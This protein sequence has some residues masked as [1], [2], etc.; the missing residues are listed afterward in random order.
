MSKECL[1]ET[2]G[3]YKSF[4]PTRAL[5]DV[6]IQ[7][8]RGEVRGLI[9][10]NGSGK[11]TLSSIIA[12]AQ[13]A[14]EGEMFLR[15]EPYLPKGNVDAQKQ[16]ISMVVQEMGTIPGISVASNIFLGNLNRFAKNGILN[17]SKMNKAAKEI[18]TE[19]GVPEID[20][21]MLINNLNFEDRKIVELARAMYTNPDVL[22]I[23]E[24][25]TALAQKGRTL[26]YRIIEKMHKENKAVL[27]I[28][29]DLDELMNVCNNITV[30]RDGNLIDTLTKEEMSIEKMRRL[31]VGR[32]LKGN[33][34]RSDYD[35]SHSEEVILDIK[36]ITT[37]VNVENFSLQLH[38]GEI[39]GIGGLSD[40]G[41]HEVGRVAFGIDKPLTGEVRLVEKDVV[42]ENPQIAI[43]NKMGYVSKDRDKEALILN[44]SIKDNI[45]LPS[46]PMLEKSFIITKA[47]EKNLANE[48]VEQ[49]EIK[50]YSSN[51]KC[52]EL[53]GGNKQK[54]VF[55]KWLGNQSEILILDCPTRGIDVGVKAKMYQLMYQL[56]KEGK[57]I[58]MISEELPELIGMSD[59]IIIM[60]DGKIKK[61]F[62]RSESLSE[63]EIIEYMI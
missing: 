30:L 28:S 19:I 15:G 36:Q 24:T 21:S 35:G 54:V 3:I 18:L 20:P 17:I 50:C 57:S 44:G 49:M 37:G 23:D 11:S 59:R 63:Q 32:E 8:R 48:N 2:K 13:A 6:S 7:V 62:L 41:M 38:K 53:S 26:L 40:C 39:L 52:D 27:F 29:H 9:G 58:I 45:T 55:A 56:K 12:G 31:M 61:E 4:G 34:Y 14:D 5:V 43:K 60:K 25:T 22:I 46:L 1:L 16:G 10:E 42:V 33:Y 47:S 51:Q